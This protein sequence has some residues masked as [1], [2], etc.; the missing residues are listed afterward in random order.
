ML[1]RDGHQ[2]GGV[3]ALYRALSLN[4]VLRGGD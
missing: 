2:F 1:P 4:S 3:A